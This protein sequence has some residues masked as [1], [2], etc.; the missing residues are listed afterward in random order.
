MH[1]EA[2]RALTGVCHV[3][4]LAIAYALTYAVERPVA[5]LFG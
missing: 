1:S 3:V 2:L 5:D 4:L